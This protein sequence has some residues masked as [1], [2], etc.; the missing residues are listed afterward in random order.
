M[1]AELVEAPVRPFDR[2]RVQL[3]ASGDISGSGH[4]FVADTH[5]WR[6]A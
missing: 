4:I 5:T 1:L 2:L 3:R 6:M